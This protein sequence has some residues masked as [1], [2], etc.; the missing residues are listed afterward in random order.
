MKPTIDRREFVVQSS[1]AAIAGAAAIGAAAAAVPSLASGAAPSS[2][3]LRVG[4]MGLG[5]GLALASALASL[6]EAEV[7]YL[8]DVRQPP[9]RRR[10]R[11]D[12]RQAS[13]QAARSRRFSQ[14]SRRQ[15]DRCSGDRRPRSLARSGDDPRLLGRQAC[16]CRKTVQPQSARRRASD[17]RG[18]QT[19]SDRA[20]RH[21][22]AKLAGHYRS[23]RK[24][25]RRRNRPSALCPLLVCRPSPLDRQGEAGGGARVDRLQFVARPGAGAALQR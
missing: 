8:C 16:L 14:D 3:P 11:A 24:S 21:A 18:P 15:I 20:G 25:P 17:R 12:R 9:A 22:A 13:P 1:T 23:D 10:H 4:V 6:P 19:Q 2:D 5:R 7:A